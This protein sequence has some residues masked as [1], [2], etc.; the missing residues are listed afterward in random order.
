MI[1]QKDSRQVGKR[2]VVEPDKF[3][4]IVSLSTVAIRLHEAFYVME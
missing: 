1:H 2:L 4:I 3:K